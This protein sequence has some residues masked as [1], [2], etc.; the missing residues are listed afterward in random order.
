MKESLV[1]T[2]SKR[3]L[4]KTKFGKWFFWKIYFKIWC[5]WRP[6]MISKICWALSELIL[7]MLP[8]KQREELL[9]E[10]E[11]IDVIIKNDNL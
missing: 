7:K 6:L 3:K 11:E 10:Y 4:P 1:I 9:K 5:I 2:F 8:K